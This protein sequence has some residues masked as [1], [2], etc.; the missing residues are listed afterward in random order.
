[1][2]NVNNVKCYYMKK[3]LDFLLEKGAIT[4]E[5]HKRACRYNAE[6]LHPDPGYIREWIFWPECGSV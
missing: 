1:M 4:Q 2:N 6:I 3:A 5:E